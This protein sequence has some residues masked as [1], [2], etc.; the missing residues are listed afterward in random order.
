MIS[1][2]WF[3]CNKMIGELSGPGEGQGGAGDHVEHQQG[4]TDMKSNANLSPFSKSLSWKKKHLRDAFLARSWNWQIF[5]QRLFWNGDTVS[6]WKAG[7]F[8]RLIM[9]TIGQRVHIA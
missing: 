5:C 9:S 7:A 6:E 8:N 3:L 1:M 4:S 2:E